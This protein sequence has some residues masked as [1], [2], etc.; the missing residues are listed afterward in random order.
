MKLLY[1]H[2]NKFYKF[3]DDYYSNG[4]FSKEVLLRYTNAFEKVKFV[5]RQVAIKDKPEKM[6]I[7]NTENVEFIKIPDFHSL[8]NYYKKKEAKKIIQNEII[9]SD[10]VI[11]RLPSLI[12]NLAIG[13][14]KKYNV[15]YLIEIVGCPWDSLWNY[16][17]KGKIIAP[18]MYFAMKIVVKNAPFAI[19]VTNEFLQHRYPCKGK[20]IGCSDVSLPMQDESILKNRIRKIKNMADNKTIVIGTI[21]AVNVRYK[22]QEY[23]IKAVSKLNKE[24]YNFE[25]HLVGGGDNSYLKSV[26]EKYGVLEKVKFLGTLPHKMVFEYL[27]N[28]DIY[29]QPSKTEGLPRALVEAMSRGCPALGSKIGGIPELLKEEFLFHN[30]SISEIYKLLKS[31]NKEI[32]LKEAKRNFE[33]AQNY[34]KKLLDKKRDNFYKKFIESIGGKYD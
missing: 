20:S 25:Y 27:D 33:K 7:V 8:R 3:K 14:A 30:G 31:I 1:A 16:S 12:G 19:Y 34:D 29:I 4:S 26:A 13:Y 23:V 2:D 21:A 18:Y 15:P 32:M 22:G 5:S 24:G 6:T 10:C 9:N 28:I 17:L 11:A